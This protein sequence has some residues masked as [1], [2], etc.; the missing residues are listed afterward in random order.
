MVSNGWGLQKKELKR[1][2]FNCLSW[3]IMKKNNERD[4]MPF[5][6]KNI[7]NQIVEQNS[8]LSVKW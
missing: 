7:K 1:R 8:S 6:Q 4:K 3:P 2:R 5:V